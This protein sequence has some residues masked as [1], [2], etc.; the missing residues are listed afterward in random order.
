MCKDGKCRQNPSDKRPVVI[1]LG[2]A[3]R[4]MAALTGRPQMVVQMNGFLAIGDADPDLVS[5]P[6]VPLIISVDSA[7]TDEE[8]ARKADRFLIRQSTSRAS[9]LIQMLEAVLGSS[10]DSHR[11]QQAPVPADQS[12]S[13]A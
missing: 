10:R 1:S 6:G 13:G 4:D 5:L 11:G 2:L 12:A 8:V 3:A 7:T 9:A